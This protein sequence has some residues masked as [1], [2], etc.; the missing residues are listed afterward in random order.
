MFGRI[1]ILIDGSP[2]DRHALEYGIG[3]GR[4]SN[5]EVHVVGVIE[6]PTVASSID[7]VKD[8]EDEGRYLLDSAL[9][10]ARDYAGR[11]GQPITT[12]VLVGPLVDTVTR[13]IQ[14]RGS[15]L[16]VVGAVDESLDRGHRGITQRAPCPVFIAREN[17][18]QEFVGAPEHRTEHWE[19]RREKRT[20]IEGPGRMLQIFIAEQEKAEGRP[21]YELIVE[22]LRQLDIAG[23]TVFPGELGFGAAGHL[24]AAKRLPWSHDH[25]IVITVVDVEDA[26][27]RAIDRVSD[28]VANGLILTSDVDIIKYAHRQH[29]AVE[30][31]ETD[32]RPV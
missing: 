29:S 8:I 10:A 20:R 25:S 4:S 27:R 26:V 5:A 9:R 30:R 21:I 23:A 7:E 28:L 22:R 3:L 32:A 1:L 18:V 6:I 12:E 19:V 14:T 17:I 24:H 31:A 11:E 15:N 13:T 16:L 2:G